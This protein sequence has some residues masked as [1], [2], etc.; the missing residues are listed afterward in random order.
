MGQLIALEWD[1]NEARVVAGSPRG[2][3]VVVEQAFSVDLP[4][5]APGGDLSASDIGTR[6]AAEFSSRGLAGG[7]ALVAVPRSNIELR[8]VSLPQAPPAEIPDMVR[9]QAMQAFTSIGEDWPLDFVELETHRDSITIL[10]AVA[11]PAEVDKVRQVCAACDCTS[12]CLVLRP[13]AAVSLLHHYQG[14]DADPGS[15]MV[16]LLADGADLTALSNGHVLF[17]RSIR[18][19]AEG[20]DETQSAALIGELRRTIGAAQNQ[21]GGSRIEQIIVCGNPTQH[22]VLR[23]KIAEVLSLDV[24]PFDPFEA[25]SL[26][27]QLK[28]NL[29]ENAG[30]FAPLL[31]MLV[32][33][34]TETGH[35][36]DFLNPRKRPQPP[37]RRRRNLLG[38]ATAVLVLAAGVT[39][40]FS[41]KQKYDNE[42]TR[43]SQESAQL[44]TAV[45][46]A[47]NLVAKA[48]RIKLFTDGDIT[49][50]DELREVA[51]RLPAA[52]HL[53]L[54]EIS[55]GANQE[56]GGRM[57]LKGNVSTAEAIADLEE[58]LRYRD[59]V[60][61]GKMGIVDRSNPDYPYQLDTTIIVPPDARENGHSLGRPQQE[62]ASPPSAE[63][64]DTT[65]GSDTPGPLTTRT[66][67]VNETSAGAPGG[68]PEKTE[69]EVGK[70]E[71]SERDRGAAA[72][73]AAPA[74]DMAPVESEDHGRH[75]LEKATDAGSD[76]ADTDAREQPEEH[77]STDHDAP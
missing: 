58:S 41:Q 20:D 67:P 45:E 33:D 30:R 64:E 19:P 48:D 29:P 62:A 4:V 40:F 57:I 76:E 47:R 68:S 1:R 74:N 26:S 31:G 15:L 73:A 39:V 25:V 55:I 61:Q 2:N 18:L 69:P 28:K 44:D 22:T 49:W 36:I 46:K 71:A 14:I 6:L 32:S 13:F 37:S 24:I 21:M 12:H 75:D 34:V 50:L 5:T 16:D 27:R 65:G 51:V 3:D 10:A 70:H 77:G 8:T 56:R 52:D 60:V 17:M 23:R 7:D 35:G 42:I 11:S 72:A 9:F 43:L 38:A 59:N 53:I 63:R 66:Q 54:Q